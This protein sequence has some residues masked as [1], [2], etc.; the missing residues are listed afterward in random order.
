MTAKIPFYL[1]LLLALVSCKEE[2]FDIDHASSSI[3]TCYNQ[4]EIGGLDTKI[5]ECLDVYEAEH[6][7][8]IQKFFSQ[9]SGMNAIYHFSLSTIEHML[10]ACDNFSTK[11]R[12]C[13]W[14]STLWTRA[15]R[16]SR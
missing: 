15:W 9:D 1:L 6:R 7:A 3:C 14:T 2:K 13:T 10:V 11:R 8:D 4:K 5:A 16:I 12:K